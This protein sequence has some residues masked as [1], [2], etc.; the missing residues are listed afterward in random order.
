VYC[1]EKK[2]WNTEDAVGAVARQSGVGRSALAYGGRKDRHAKTKQFITVRGKKT[3]TFSHKAITLTFVGWMD[4]PMGPDLIQGNRFTVVV[5]GLSAERAAEISGVA[6]QLSSQGFPNYFDDQRFGSFVPGEGFFAQKLLQ[7][8]LNGAL[9]MYMVSMPREENTKERARRNYFAAHWRDWKACA[10]EAATAFERG[11]F[12]LLI[13][14]PNAFVTAL[15][16]ISRAELSIFFAALQAHIFNEAL[17]ILIQETFGGA[18]ERVNGSAG[19]YL[20]YRA[21]SDEQ[22]AH[23]SGRTLP[24]AAARV[25][26]CDEQCGRA[27]EEALARAGLRRQMFN[28]MEL[29]KTFFRSV[30]RAAIVFPREVRVAQ[31]PDARYPGMHALTLHFVLPRGSYG[32]MLLKRILLNSP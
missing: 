29:R 27:Y 10:S 7:G 4:R 16:R 30:D 25:A 14:S 13:K 18:V 8:H 24:L 9:K 20:F 22:R 11:V 21:L 28:K 5:R 2:G 17:R 23:W 1:L 32:T 31:E 6:Q 3:N 12:A 19:E 26:H 15:N